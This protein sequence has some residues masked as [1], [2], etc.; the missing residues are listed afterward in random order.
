MKATV[1]RHGIA[2]RGHTPAA[3][4]RQAARDNEELLDISSQ[5]ADALVAAHSKGIVHRDIKPANI[6][7]TQR[8]EVKIL[9]F[10]LAKLVA[11]RL[12]RPLVRIPSK[13]DALVGPAL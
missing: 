3:P 1:H 9:D 6:F 13:I 4:W 5:I 10:G 12:P 11:E 8:S 7:M 2:G